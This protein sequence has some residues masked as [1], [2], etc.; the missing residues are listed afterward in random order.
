MMRTLS[1]TAQYAENRCEVS[2]P[3]KDDFHY[4]VDDF[5]FCSAD[6]LFAQFS[7]PGNSA[8]GAP[9]AR[10]G[11]TPDITLTG[12][13]QITQVVDPSARTITNITQEGHRY[14]SGTVEIRVAPTWY[15]SSV[16]ILGRGTTSRY[17]ENSILGGVL[18]RAL[19]TRAKIACTVG[20][21]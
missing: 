14:H 13:N 17:W 6:D 11:T 8:P 5:A 10:P 1:I 21:K 4:K 3:Q 15:G 19:S 9:A 16:S 2:L 12:G 7:K 20:A 18:F